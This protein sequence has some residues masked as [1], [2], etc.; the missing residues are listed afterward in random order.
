MQ[1]GKRLGLKEARKIIDAIIYASEKSEGLPMAT[2]VVN[3][4]GD[5]VY[6]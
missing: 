2:A 1:K 6:F 3:Q 5:L 4:H